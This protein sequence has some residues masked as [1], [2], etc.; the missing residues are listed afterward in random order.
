[1]MRKTFPTLLALFLSL[2]CFGSIGQ[3]AEKHSVRHRPRHS[4]R[5]TTAPSTTKKKATKARHQVRRTTH[6][7]SKRKTITKPK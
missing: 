7:A 4:A 2:F 5:V 1:M 3:A 6:A